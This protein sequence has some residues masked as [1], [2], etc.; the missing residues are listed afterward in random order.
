MPSPITDSEDFRRRIDAAVELLFALVTESLGWATIALLDQDVDGANRVIA[1]DRAIDEHC[2]EISGLVKE[3]LSEQPL[4]PEEIEGLVAVIQIVP[5]LE[6]SADL[7]KHIAQRSLRGLGGIITPRSRGLIQA[8]SEIGIGMWRLAASAYSKRSRDVTFDLYE[9]DRELDELAASLVAEGVAEGG[10]ARVAVDLALIAR[11]YERLGDHAVNLARRV[12]TMS[13]LRRS[14]TPGVFG[15]VRKRAGPRSAGGRRARR[16]TKEKK[17]PV[18]RLFAG[19]PEAAPTHEAFFELFEAAAANTRD[20]ATELRK[21]TAS[22]SDLDAHFEEIKGFEHRGDQITGALLRLLDESPTTPF[23]REDIH[24]LAEEL[25]D[26]VDEMFS[27][28]SL[29]QL[30]SVEQPPPEVAQ[31][32]DVL[33]SMAD[34]I[35]ALMDCLRSREGARHRLERIE[36]LERQGDAIFRTS[37]ARLFSGEYEAMQILK[38][39]DIVQAIED[40]L[41]AIEDV[42]DVVESILVK[43]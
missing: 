15:R 38:W 19:A 34:E 6:R 11:F 9:S 33:V 20:C 7:A 29:I 35:V 12:E 18:S 1:D 40:S 31:L 26:V 13:A 14:P 10:D 24:S 43:H 16:T 42:S 4:D 27:A 25:D 2:E 37:I 23:D 8:M 30:V 17:G 28:A 36:H 5:E 39:K 3:R 21:L 22:F 32:S 41:N